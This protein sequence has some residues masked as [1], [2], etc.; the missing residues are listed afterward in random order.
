[1]KE[2]RRFVV[3]VVELLLSIDNFIQLKGFYVNARP[4]NKGSQQIEGVI[5]RK[6]GSI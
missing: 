5:D 4:Q 6:R 2:K 3:V 1:V